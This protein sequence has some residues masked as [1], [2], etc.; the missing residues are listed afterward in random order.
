MKCP[1]CRAQLSKPDDAC[2]VC[3]NVVSPKRPAPP[4]AEKPKPDP[5][6]LPPANAVIRRAL[7]DQHAKAVAFI[8]QYR[9]QHPDA[10]PEQASMAMLR[11]GRK[12][13]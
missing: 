1:V 3:G 8:A 12:A 10:T 9:A 4:R 5:V 2:N 7:A 11:H 6:A 13:G